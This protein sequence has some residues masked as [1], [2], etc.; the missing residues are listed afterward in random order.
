V[1]TAA[2]GAEGLA[3]L[4]EE[5]IPLVLLDLCLPGM[6]G[7]EVLHHITT[8]APGTAVVILSAVQDLA[9]IEAALHG[10]AVDFLPKPCDGT[11][12]CARLHRA[13]IHAPSRRPCP[14]PPA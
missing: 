3:R 2:T 13:L 7:L 9:T 6:P 5:I 1:V 10:G 4:A 8:Q 14:M 11:L 12:L